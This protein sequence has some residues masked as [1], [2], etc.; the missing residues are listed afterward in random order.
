[1]VGHQQDSLSPATH[2]NVYLIQRMLKSS[3]HHVVEIQVALQP[4]S[5][6]PSLSCTIL[7][8]LQLPL[9]A[10]HIQQNGSPLPTL[11][12][13]GTIP[14]PPVLLGWRTSGVTHNHHHWGQRM[15]GEGVML[16]LKLCIPSKSRPSFGPVLL[17]GCWLCYFCFLSYDFVYAQCSL[18]A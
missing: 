6:I 14:G 13:W 4:T 15:E 18:L 1:M 5:D 7:S 11:V 9:L 17:R 8:P 10:S 16:L 12:R 2:C 3:L